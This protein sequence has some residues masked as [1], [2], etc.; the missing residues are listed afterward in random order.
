MLPMAKGS[1]KQRRRQLAKKETAVRARAAL[2]SRPVDAHLRGELENAWSH[3]REASGAEEEGGIAEEEMYLE[4]DEWLA[5]GSEQGRY[6]FRYRA[7][8]DSLSTFWLTWSELYE[9]SQG[10]LSIMMTPEP[11]W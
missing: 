11:H 6:F 8:D 2:V 7:Q 10:R 4:P 3:I 1:E 5:G 9:V